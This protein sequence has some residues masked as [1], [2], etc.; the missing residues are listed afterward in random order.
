MSKTLKWYVVN[1]YSGFEDKVTQT[2]REQA[3]KKGLAEKFGEILVPREEIVEIRKG[4]KVN[5][6][7][8]FFPGYILVEM[9]LTDDTWHLVKYTPKVS[10][11]LG[12]KGRPVPVS[13]K[14]VDRILSQIE[15]NAE[16]P[17]VTII[18]D[19]GEQVRVSDG[20]FASFV[21]L[22]EEVDEEKS[23]L[24][25]SVTIFGRSTPVDL[26]FSQVEKL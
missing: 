20:P 19:I 12:G 17:R 21:G 13:K 10:G 18:Y 9:E 6:E 22:V 25:V 15:E 16:K 14:E 1:V 5:T 2:I 24:K 4:T 8:K 7:Q 11:F 23:R 26:D 3:E